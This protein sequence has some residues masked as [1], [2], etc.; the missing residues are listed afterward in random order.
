M[1]IRIQ[2]LLV[3]DDEISAQAARTLLERLG[4]RKIVIEPPFERVR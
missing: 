3:E 1:S 4:W 2:V